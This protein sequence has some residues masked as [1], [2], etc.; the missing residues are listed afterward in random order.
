ML[1]KCTSCG[2]N[3]NINEASTCGYC[4]NLIE[5]ESAVDFYNSSVSGNNG[6]LVIM[7]ETATA[8]GNFEDAVLYFNKILE[9]DSTNPDAWLGK[10]IA[11]VNTSKIGNLKIKEAISYWMLAIDYS[12]DKEAM[13]RRVALEIHQIV[14][15]FYPTLENYFIQF[16][17]V[18]LTF[19]EHLQRY[20][21]LNSALEYALKLDPKNLEIIKTGIRL[22]KRVKPS[23]LASRKPKNQELTEKEKIRWKALSELPES[24]LTIGIRKKYFDILEI[25][26]P[27]L[28]QKVKEWEL[29]CERIQKIS[30]KQLNKIIGITVSVGLITFLISNL[31]TKDEGALFWLS[32][33]G[34][35]IG[36]VIGNVL[37]KIPSKP[38]GIPG[39]D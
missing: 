29:E 32:V 21:L 2:A 34:A 11:T 28:F 1:V 7:A 8:S 14:S 35:I 22:S 4:G 13:S 3:Q 25:A 37:I 19:F 12:K 31:I 33:L 10:G 17:T 6:Y 16:I 9:L 26:D 39:F 20:I 23:A 30:D 38:D 15:S 27:I 5:I 36:F 18:N 24:D